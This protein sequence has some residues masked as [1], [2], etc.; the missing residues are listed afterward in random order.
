MLTLI[1]KNIPKGLLLRLKVS[2][3]KNHRSLNSEILTRLESE[4]AAP[5]VDFEILAGRLHA[6]TARLPRTDHGKI[7]RYKQQG[8]T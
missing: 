7:S 6:F 4:F 5:V 1:L 8:R 3:E 2:A